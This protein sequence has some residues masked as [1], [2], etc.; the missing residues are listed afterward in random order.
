MAGVLERSGFLFYQFQFLRNRLALRLRRVRE[1][2]KVFFLQRERYVSPRLESSFLPT[3]TQCTLLGGGADNLGT[4][5]TE[6]L[7]I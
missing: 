3:V 7:W 1:L 4:G 5:H 6:I 2:W